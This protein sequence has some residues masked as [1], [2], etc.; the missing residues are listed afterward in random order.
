MGHE[1]EKIKTTQCAIFYYLNILSIYIYQQNFQFLSCNSL[2]ASGCVIYSVQNTAAD[3][4]SNSYELFSCHS[5]SDHFVVDLA[6][7][8]LKNLASTCGHGIGHDGNIF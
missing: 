3:A 5:I 7:D 6:T 4:A 2:A 1:K 8:Y